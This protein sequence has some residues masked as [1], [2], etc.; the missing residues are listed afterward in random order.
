MNKDEFKKI[1]EERKVSIEYTAELTEEELNALIDEIYN[2]LY[3]RAY[4]ST[5]TE[6]AKEEVD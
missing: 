6:K 1:C 4:C 5:T 3:L 2:A